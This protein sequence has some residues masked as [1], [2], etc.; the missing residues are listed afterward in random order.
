MGYAKNIPATLNLVPMDEVS[1]TSRWK[2]ALF[3]SVVAVVVTAVFTY[4][5]IFNWQTHVPGFK[6]ADSLEHA[7]FAWWFD[8]AIF[9]LDQSPAE[10]TYLFH[11]LHVE[12]PLLTAMAWSRFVPMIA[13]HFGS[14]LTATYNAH[15]FIE[16]IR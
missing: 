13:I 7:W 12:H 5:L 15:I 16:S 1:Q 11:P 14:S 10:L 2:F 3:V 4:P 6:F 9:T 8:Y